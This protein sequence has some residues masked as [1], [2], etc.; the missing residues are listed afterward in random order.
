MSAEIMNPGVRGWEGN[1]EW[2]ERDRHFFAN[3]DSGL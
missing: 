1:A 2:G 3:K